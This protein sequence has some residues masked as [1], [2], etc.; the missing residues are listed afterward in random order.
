MLTILYII[1]IS[2]V[3]SGPTNHGVITVDTKEN[4]TPKHETTKA[5]HVGDTSKNAVA[6]RQNNVVSASD[7]VA[8]KHIGA[9]VSHGDAKE[10]ESKWQHIKPSMKNN[11]A[12]TEDDEDSAKHQEQTYKNTAFSP[13]HHGEPVFTDSD[14]RKSAIAGLLGNS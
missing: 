5:K 13:G 6:V 7:D 12:A 9:T 2:S 14:K 10:D 3:N 11:K 1:I 4:A 8:V